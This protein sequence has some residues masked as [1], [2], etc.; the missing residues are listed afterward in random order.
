[1]ILILA[2]LNDVHASAVAAALEALGHRCRI[3]RGDEFP[4]SA[5]VSLSHPDG[6]A[7]VREHPDSEPLAWSQIRVVWNRRRGT[8]RAPAWLAEPDRDPAV[9]ASRRVID[10]LRALRPE[11][12]IWVNDPAAGERSDDKA[13]QL[14]FAREQGFETPE[15]LISNDPERIRAFVAAGPSVVKSLV[16]IHWQGRV[17]ATRPI[18][19]AQL[20]RDRAVA[21]CPMIYQRLVEKSH[22]LRVV[23]FGAELVACRIDSQKRAAT[24]TDFRIGLYADLE[25]EQVELAPAVRASVL[26]FM[27]A[28]GLLHAS[29]DIAVDREGRPV[30]LEVN[31]QGQTLWI[32]D[33]NPA[34]RILDRLSAFL[35]APH[36]EFRWDRV[37]RFAFDAEA[38]A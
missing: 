32:E 25:V 22:E 10:S 19:I 26:G 4:A 38:W 30:F 28:A 3:F 23:V 35:A 21:A 34:I 18:G 12:Q 9:R 31:E 2:A 14:G 6:E 17:A 7:W 15:T 24:V 20:A 16:P 13:W 8:P 1:M 36:P 5:Q 29:F 33:R 37:R 27:R 11:G